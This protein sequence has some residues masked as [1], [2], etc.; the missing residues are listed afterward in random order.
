MGGSACGGRQNDWSFIFVVPDFD[1]TVQ[2]DRR[3]V[4]DPVVWTY[5]DYSLYANQIWG[6][7]ICLFGSFCF[8]ARVKIEF[9]T[10]IQRWK[11]NGYYYDLSSWINW[12]RSRINILFHSITEGNLQ[13]EFNV[14]SVIETPD[15]WDSPG[16]IT[17]PN[18]IN[19]Y[20][21]VKPYDIV[22]FFIEPYFCAETEGFVTY[23]A[24]N[25]DYLNILYC[26]VRFETGYFL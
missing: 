2:A 7:G 3:L 10:R 4:I 14:F 16:T 8:G 15:H 9:Y 18:P 23:A 11:W 24:L 25:I 12:R 5:G 22:Q 26:V 19:N 21:T 1:T 20:G 6:S 13:Q 17:Q